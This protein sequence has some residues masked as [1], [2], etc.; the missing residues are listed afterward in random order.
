MNVAHDERV[1]PGASLAGARVAPGVTRTAR[2][3]SFMNSP[4]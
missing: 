4:G 2:A 1:A 3:M